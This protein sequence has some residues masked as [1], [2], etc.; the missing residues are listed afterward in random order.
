MKKILYLVTEDWYFWSHRR[1]LAEQ[2]I[3]AGYKVSLVTKPGAYSEKISAMGINVFPVDIA[4][5]ISSPLRELKTIYILIGI[6]RKVSPDLLHHV[7]LKSIFL[8][9]IASLFARSPKIINA[10]TGLGYIF[11]STTWFSKLFRLFFFSMLSLLTRSNKYYSIVQNNDDAILLK[12]RGLIHYDRYTLIPGSGVD[13]EE[14]K[15]TPE[16]D[17]NIPIVMFASRLLVDKGIYD[18]IEACKLIKKDNVSSKFILVGSVDLQNP[19]SINESEVESWVEDYL[20]EWW[21]CRSDMYEVICQSNIICLPSYREGLPKVLLE[22]ASIGRAIVA[23][24]VP[25][26]RDCVQN[27][28]N[29]FTV[30]PRDPV[31]LALAIKQL[32]GADETRRKMGK[33]GHDMIR[34]RYDVST[35]N[36]RTLS[37]YNDLV[38]DQ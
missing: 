31:S 12:D 11:I 8:G 2:A 35:I 15:Y 17:T 5:S 13:I 1:H 28:V 30:P 36:H 6:Y 14:F 32:I 38:N 7:S 34:N 21:G 18:F 10:Y 22:A 26:C 29:G 20:V 16:Q 23:T 25:G 3:K 24:D 33:A 37:L 9:S 4:R 19:S 27:G